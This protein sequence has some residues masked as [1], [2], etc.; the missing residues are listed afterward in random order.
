MKPVLLRALTVGLV[1][2]SM[3]FSPAAA[4]RPHS[5]LTALWTAGLENIELASS[6]KGNQDSGKFPA[7]VL[8]M[9]YEALP[10]LTTTRAAHSLRPDQATQ[11]YPIH[12]HAIVTYYDPDTD[13]NVGAFFACDRT[14]CICVLTPRRPILP[15]RAGSLIDMTGVSGPGSYAP[16]VILVDVHV[17]GQGQL[18]ATPPRRSLSQLMTGADDGQFVEVEGVVHSVT[19]SGHN[20]NFSLALA[21]GMIG[22]ITP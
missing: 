4:Q 18:P 9:S 22:G 7:D 6:L 13:P 14:G 8:A 15:L 21:D 10:T 12:L 2:L 17:V 19:Q 16:V 20:V 3:P 1:L 11:Q 5:G